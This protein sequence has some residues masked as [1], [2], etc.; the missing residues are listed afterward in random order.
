MWIHRFFN[1]FRAVEGSGMDEGQQ[2]PCV[3]HKLSTVLMSTS[4]NGP[5]L[6]PMARHRDSKQ[7]IVSANILVFSITYC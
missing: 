7:G 6:V 1:R 3:L 2:S 4:V 5:G